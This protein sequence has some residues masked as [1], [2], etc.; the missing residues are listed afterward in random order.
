MSVFSASAHGAES[1]ATVQFMDFRKQSQAPLCFW[2][3]LRG[4]I[5]GSLTILLHVSEE[6]RIIGC[7]VSA[8]VC[9]SNSISGF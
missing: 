9:R 5:T 7:M 1:A 3:F 8:G 4:A 6:I 2:M